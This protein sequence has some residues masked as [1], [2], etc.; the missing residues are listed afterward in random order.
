LLLPWF[1]RHWVVDFWILQL[2]IGKHIV[3]VVVRSL[4]FTDNKRL[5]DVTISLGLESEATEKSCIGLFVI[6]FI[7]SWLWEFQLLFALLNL[8]RQSDPWRFLMQHVLFESKV[9]SNLVLGIW[10]VF[11]RS[12]EV[13]KI[14][15]WLDFFVNSKDDRL[16]NIMM[17]EFHLITRN[18]HLRGLFGTHFDRVC[19]RKG[20]LFHLRRRSSYWLMSLL[21]RFSSVWFWVTNHS[22]GRSRSGISIPTWALEGVS[23]SCILPIVKSS[24][25]SVH[26]IIVNYRHE[27]VF[28][29][30]TLLSDWR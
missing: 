21:S 7:S 20:I 5:F 24:S 25:S 30:S 14:V 22:K 12:K 15:P 23:G 9:F 18:T 8:H 13:I 26:L 29:E 16:V 19:D 17:P 11:F 10:D 4:F 3:F 2:L 6:N 1:L 28:L 27:I